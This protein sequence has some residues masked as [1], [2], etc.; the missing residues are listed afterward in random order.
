MTT[1]HMEHLDPGRIVHQSLAPLTALVVAT[2]TTRSFAT[3]ALIRPGRVDK[4]VHF[5]LASMLQV[6]RMFLR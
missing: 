4:V 1:N 2:L 6:E 5:G 3:T